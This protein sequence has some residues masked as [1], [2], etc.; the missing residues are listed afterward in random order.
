VLARIRTVVALG[1]L[2]AALALTA[3]QAPAL[4]S[5][6]PFADPYVIGGIG[7]CTAA[8]HEFY[9]GG[10]YDKPFAPIAVATAKASGDYSRPGRKAVLYAFQPR[11]YLDPSFWEGN[12]LSADSSYSNPNVPMVQST[13]IDPSLAVFLA[14]YPPTWNGY[15]EMRVFDGHIGAGYDTTNYAATILQVRGTTWTALNAPKVNCRSGHAV[16][17]ES[18]L[19]AKE[20]RYYERLQ[21]K[22]KVIETVHGPVSVVPP[23]QA[24]TRVMVTPTPSPGS[25]ASPK[26]KTGAATDTDTPRSE[27]VKSVTSLYST[28]SS[29]ISGARIA[30]IVVGVACLLGLVGSYAWS[31]RRRGGSATP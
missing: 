5:S 12:P 9:S 21:A 28:P 6:R 19:D 10:I 31:R 1:G 2:G 7:F 11:Q 22:Q 14:E 24:P 4:A 18:L 27:K 25:S 23:K 13:I 20:F 16:S 17:A 26:A 3:G 8:G 30:E 29:S 15:V